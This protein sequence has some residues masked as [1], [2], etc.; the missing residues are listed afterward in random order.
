L[1]RWLAIACSIALAS[2]S[3]AAKRIVIMEPPLARACQ[4]AKTWP[5]LVDCLKQ[6][7][8]KATISRQIDGAKLLVVQ[9]IE[10]KHGEIETWALYVAN[11][12]GWKLG[13]LMNDGGNLAD[14]EVLR[15]ER[16]TAGAHHGFRFDIAMTQQSAVSLDQ[17]TSQTSTLRQTQATFCS[18]I[19]YSCM[20]IVPSCV[21]LV[22]G[23]AVLAFEGQITVAD[24][25]ITLTGTGTLPQSCSGAA[26]YSAMLQ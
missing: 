11:G 7:G 19:G 13:G 3:A 15:F 25:L 2:R 24:N 23:Q 5:L 9:S 10:A 26:T 18:G 21:Q 6:H 16:I 17:V 22:Y 4:T 12:T 20:T 8:L 14:T 1:L